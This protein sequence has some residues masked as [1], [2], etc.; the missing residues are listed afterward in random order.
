[1]SLQDLIIAKIIQIRSKYADDDE[2][3]KLLEKLDLKI[4]SKAIRNKYR[5]I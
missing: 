3:Y 1:M 5:I 2:F 4:K